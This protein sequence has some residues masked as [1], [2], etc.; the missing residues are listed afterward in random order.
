ML[1]KVL[2]L[3]TEETLSADGWCFTGDV[4]LWDSHGRLKIIDRVK[5]IFKLSQGEY[6]APEKVE[7]V[8]QRHEA[9]FQAF[10]YG[11][12]LQSFL[13]GVV[14]KKSF[15]V[16]FLTFDSRRRNCLYTMGSISWI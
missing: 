13:V 9:V 8:L 7:M 16:N 6:I 3:K 2:I 12:S 5:N 15:L 1:K 11:D 14:G 4:G 10:V